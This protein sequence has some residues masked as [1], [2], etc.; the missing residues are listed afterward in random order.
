MDPKNY[1]NKDHKRIKATTK[2]GDVNELDP[3][4][5][6]LLKDGLD[7]DG[8]TYPKNIKVTDYIDNQK[9][10]DKETVLKTYS[11]NNFN[12]VI[13]K[14][15]NDDVICPEFSKKKKFTF[16]FSLNGLNPF[17]VYKYVIQLTNN[18]KMTPRRMYKIICRSAKHVLQDTLDF[19]KEHKYKDQI[20]D[21]NN[22]LNELEIEYVGVKIKKTV[23]YVGYS[24][25]EVIDPRNTL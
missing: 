20:F 17:H 11:D 15:D 3:D 6:I 5:E 12:D 10:L 16:I 25:F 9:K 19:V 14:L 8:E 2:L 22:K 18:N 1:T 13:E 23:I 24:G 7:E 21:I 4:F